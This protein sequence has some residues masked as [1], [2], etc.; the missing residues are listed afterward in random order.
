[1]WLESPSMAAL[2]DVRHQA[3]EVLQAAGCSDAGRRDVALVVSE[4]LTNAIRHGSPPVEVNVELGPPECRISVFDSG[5]GV[6]RLVRPPALASS[7]R[8]VL[9]V[10]A[11]SLEWGVALA[12]PGKVVWA[13][14]QV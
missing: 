8:G 14:V 4:L 10:D 2:A 3:D 9:I 1:M 7:G 13:L 6:P 11:L 12:A 5:P